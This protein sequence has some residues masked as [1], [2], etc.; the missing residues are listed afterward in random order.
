M[1]FYHN[2]TNLQVTKMNDRYFSNLS[3]ASDPGG[4]LCHWTNSSQGK[5]IICIWEIFRKSCLG[6]FYLDTALYPP[7]HNLE[8]RKSRIEQRKCMSVCIMFQH[9]FS[10]SAR[11]VEAA[12]LEASSIYDINVSIKF[13]ILKNEEL[14]SYL[15]WI[16]EL[17]L[18]GIKLRRSS[19]WS[20]FWSLS[21][22]TIFVGT[23][24]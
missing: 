17:E 13:L 22:Y 12:K 7:L 3:R 9:D 10:S 8:P 21:V 14:S 4:E 2:V 19:C 24:S 16:G 5:H 23:S 6:P 15:S 1:Q 20:Q 11:F 18:A